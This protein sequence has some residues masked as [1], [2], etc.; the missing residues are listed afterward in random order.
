MSGRVSRQAGRCR[1][2]DA[3]RNNGNN[4]DEA[5]FLLERD[6]AWPQTETRVGAS[7]G[8]P[9]ERGITTT[10]TAAASTIIRIMITIVIRI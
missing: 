8:V 4:G 3:D 9:R 5:L 2:R 1:L 6:M 10:T 7:G